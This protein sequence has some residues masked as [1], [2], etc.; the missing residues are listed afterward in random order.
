MERPRSPGDC[1]RILN[2]NMKTDILRYIHEQIHARKAQAANQSVLKMLIGS[3]EQVL[4]IFGRNNL[5]TSVS[6]NPFNIHAKHNLDIFAYPP[7]KT[8]L[9]LN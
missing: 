6:P 9:E 8:S 3:I 4:E 7:K 1:L 2:E 5:V